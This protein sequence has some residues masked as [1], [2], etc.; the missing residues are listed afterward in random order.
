MLSAHETYKPVKRIDDSICFVKVSTWDEKV[1]L[2]SRTLPLQSCY[3][4]YPKQDFPT[5]SMLARATPLPDRSKTFTIQADTGRVYVFVT[6]DD[7]H[8]KLVRLDR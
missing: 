1:H 5:K 3:A 8:K 6:A 4:G 2:A 7:I